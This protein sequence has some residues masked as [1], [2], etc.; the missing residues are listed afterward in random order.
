VNGRRMTMMLGLADGDIPRSVRHFT[1]E[2]A[3]NWAAQGIRCLCTGF[4]EELPEV[5]SLGAAARVMLADHGIHIAQF[6]GVNANFSHHDE[7]VRAEGRRRVAQAIDA[8]TAIG[9]TMINSGCGTNSDDYRAHF[10]APHELNFS[11]AAAERLV[12]E[13]RGIA[14]AV[15]D[16][17]LLYSI[18]CHQLTTMSSPVVIR[19]VLDEVDSPAIVANFDPVNLLNSAAAVFDNAQRMQNMVETIGSRFAP[20]CHIKDVVISDQLVCHISEAAPGEGLLDLQGFFSAAASLPG[21]TA[22]IVE[23]LAPENSAAGVRF[24]RDV[25]ISCGVEFL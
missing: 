13:L 25:A 7:S 24:V 14:P 18:E 21:P 8:A 5:A 6:A 12:S 17:G 1:P 15:E 16:A 22:L 2:L 3:A 4:S 23:H 11:A 10:Y 20:S 9:A 19:Q